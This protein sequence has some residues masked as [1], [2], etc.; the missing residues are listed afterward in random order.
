[1]KQGCKA[2]VLVVVLTLLS[3][4]AWG[5]AGKK[6]SPG[7]QASKNLTYSGIPGKFT[8]RGKVQAGKQASTDNQPATVPV[9]KIRK[10]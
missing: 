1:M 7:G 5:E 2:A 3:P 8:R 9:K 6:K 4:A 10:A